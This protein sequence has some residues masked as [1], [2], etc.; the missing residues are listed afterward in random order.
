MK[1]TR[2]TFVM[3]FLAAALLT[4]CSSAAPT[5]EAASAAPAATSASR[6]TVAEGILLP[7]RSLNLAFNTNGRVAEVL[8]AEGSPVKAGEV[9]ARL[10]VPA[11]EA[12]QA[13]LAR[14]EQEAAAAQ[15]EAAAAA[16]EIVNATQAQDNLYA[17]GEVA[18]AQ[19]RYTL[20]DLDLQIDTAQED[21]DEEL[22][23]YEPDEL[24]VARLRAQLELYTTQREKAASDLAAYNSE[25]V[26]EPALEAAQARLTAAEQR[27][28]AAE[29]R[30]ASAAAAL[31][32]AEAALKGAEL[33][34]PWDGVLATSSLKAGEWVTAGVTVASL[35]DF[36][37]WYIETDN[38]T[39]T[40]VVGIQPGDTVQI[41]FD[42]LPEFA[43]TGVVEE[44]ASQFVEKRGDV[45][46]P[47]RIRLETIDPALRWGMT[48]ALRFEK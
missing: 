21:L 29:S 39:E 41:T 37:A 4:A 3:L 26:T 47:V 9:I 10:E 43:A 48:A 17:A 23:R 7:A 38:L 36:S 15:S 31:A 8:A 28:A 24:K 44:I 46:Y 33:V 6:S 5:P 19:L 20:T 32:S 35:A 25:N 34:A 42:A 11:I 45:T 14:A 22:A 12:R 16:A 1:P 40:G 2:L 30:A 18:V 13:D 27:Q